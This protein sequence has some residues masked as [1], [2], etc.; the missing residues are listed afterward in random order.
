MCDVRL[1][2][3]DGVVWRRCFSLS[4]RQKF[5][6]TCYSLF[7]LAFEHT[8][9]LRIHEPAPHTRRSVRRHV[10][11]AVSHTPGNRLKD[12][13]VKGIFTTKCHSKKK[14][15][16]LRTPS[17]YERFYS[18]GITPL[19]LS[20]SY[21]SQRHSQPHGFSAS[22]RRTLL[23]AKKTHTATTCDDGANCMNEAQES[24]IQQDTAFDSMTSPHVTSI[25][26]HA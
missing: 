24:D 8:L 17:D 18:P 6:T 5:D 22:W 1:L 19:L 13:Q 15:N 11:W 3:N 10:R 12:A 2:L 23:R 16:E 9:T 7:S 26:H 4:A 25:H 21:G 14:G 20:I